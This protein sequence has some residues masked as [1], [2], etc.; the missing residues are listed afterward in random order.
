MNITIEILKLLTSNLNYSVFHDGEN[1]EKKKKKHKSGKI[2][3]KIA[4]KKNNKDK[5]NKARKNKIQ[6]K[7]KFI[8]KQ[9]LG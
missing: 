5:K 6:K 2:I 1:L 7:K 3:K 8:P 9:S 4:K